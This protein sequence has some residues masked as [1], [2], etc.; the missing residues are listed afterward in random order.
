MNL[1]RCHSAMGELMW[2]CYKTAVLYSEELA[3]V[4]WASGRANGGKLH[5]SSTVWHVV[6]Q[7]GTGCLIVK[8]RSEH[9]WHSFTFEQ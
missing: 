2:T 3:V 9:F 7:L 1:G 4:L 5:E 6:C 8:S